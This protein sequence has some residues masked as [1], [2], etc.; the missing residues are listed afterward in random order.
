M[1]YTGQKN[2]LGFF[3]KFIVSVSAIVA[4]VIASSQIK[5]ILDT[6]R[7]SSQQ[8]EV[9]WAALKRHRLLLLDPTAQ[10][11]PKFF[12]RKTLLIFLSS[13]HDAA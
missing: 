4:L 12:Q 8:S 13:N 3:D 6:L 7:K 5:Q 10:N 2:L 1:L 11:C 9:A